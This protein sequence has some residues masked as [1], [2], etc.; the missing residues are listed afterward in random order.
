MTVTL[1]SLRADIAAMVELDPAE[2][3]DDDD[4]M[5][6]GLDSMR[7]MNLVLHWEEAGVP[8]AFP[9]LVE[10]MTLAGIWGVVRERL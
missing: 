4:L 7:T 3:G 8:I 1:E 6:L 2:I 5:A 9:D 10:T